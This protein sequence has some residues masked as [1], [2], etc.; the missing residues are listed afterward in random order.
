VE[1]KEKGRGGKKKVPQNAGRKA[2]KGE[3]MSFRSVIGKY[4]EKGARTKG[5]KRRKGKRKLFEFITNM[6][7]NVEGWGAG[8]LLVIFW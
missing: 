6:P 8:K 1:E 4:R 7:A 3:T 5:K 2:G